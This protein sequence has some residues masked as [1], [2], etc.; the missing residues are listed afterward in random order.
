MES[1]NNTNNMFQQQTID[2]RQVPDDEKE[3]I[4][5]IICRGGDFRMLTRFWKYTNKAA[6]NRI[7]Y[8]RVS[9]F[10]CA[11]CHHELPEQP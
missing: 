2:I 9:R 10:V 11:D 7:E 8:H 6:M 4:K 3:Q 1:K 5:C